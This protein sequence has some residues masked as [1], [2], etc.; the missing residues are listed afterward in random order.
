MLGHRFE[1]HQ[2]FIRNVYCRTDVVCLMEPDE[3]SQSPEAQAGL[4][5]EI[6]FRPMRAR[7]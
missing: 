1:L 6:H 7:M 3:E 5:S 4:W 2:G